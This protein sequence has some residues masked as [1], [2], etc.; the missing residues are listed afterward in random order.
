M[1][2]VIFAYWF[3]NERFQLYDYIGLIL[4]IV[5]SLIVMFTG[6]VTTNSSGFLHL[7]CYFTIHYGKGS[8]FKIIDLTLEQLIQKLSKTSSII[9]LLVLLSL[10]LPSGVYIW[11]WE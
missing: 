5:G 2:N 10:L 3:N 1:T 7:Y 9:L 4:C 6:E 8:F 11:L